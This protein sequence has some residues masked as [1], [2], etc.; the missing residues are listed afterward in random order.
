MRVVLDFTLKYKGRVRLSE[1]NVL[2][3]VKFEKA[4]PIVLRYSP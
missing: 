4:G 3:L 1:Q 2:A